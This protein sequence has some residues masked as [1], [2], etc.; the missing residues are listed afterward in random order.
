[1]L[2]LQI[3]ETR[4]VPGAGRDFRHHDQAEVETLGVDFH[5]AGIVAGDGLVLLVVVGME[6]HRVQSLSAERAAIVS[7][8]PRLQAHERMSD[9]RLRKSGA[10]GRMVFF[11]LQHAAIHG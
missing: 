10:F 9:D 1:M 3:L 11:A 2:R 7:F 5:T 8:S 6:F 4:H